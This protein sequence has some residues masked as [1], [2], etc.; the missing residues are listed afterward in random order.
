MLAD[1]VRFSGQ[2]QVSHLKGLVATDRVAK[3]F[4]LTVKVALP[5]DDG[6]LSTIPSGVVQYCASPCLQAISG[7]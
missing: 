1:C 6:A 5:D 2:Q 7:K 4:T 3:L